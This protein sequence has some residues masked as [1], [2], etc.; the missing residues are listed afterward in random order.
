MEICK[1]RACKAGGSYV[2]TCVPDRGDDVTRPDV[3]AVQVD[4]VVSTTT[5]RPKVIGFWRQGR[6]CG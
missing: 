1:H 2:K 6:A 5:G 3:P 4:W